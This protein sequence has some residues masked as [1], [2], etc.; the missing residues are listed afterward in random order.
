MKLARPV[1]MWQ[2]VADHVR[3]QILNGTYPAGQPLPSEEALAAEFGVSRP[4]IREGIKALVAE[5]LVEVAR[6]KG[7]TVRDPYGRPTRTE[8]H[9]GSTIRDDGGWAD[10]GPPN[11]YRANATVDQAE[12]LGIPAG[13]PLLVRAVIQ[14]SGGL[15]RLNRL[16]VPFSIAEQTPWADD[17]HL[18]RPREFYEHFDAEHKLIW[19]EHVRARMPIGDETTDLRIPPGVALLV[20]LRLC[21]LG[22]GRTSAPETVALEETRQRAD[23]IEVEYPIL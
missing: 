20:V 18:P 6:P 10:A 2:Q 15:R 16:Y 21:R 23:Q 4:T 22:K 13:E 5:G 14:E 12:M 8:R 3:D 17:P 19:T 11:I 7:T 9:T 1:S